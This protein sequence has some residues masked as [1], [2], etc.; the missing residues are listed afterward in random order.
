MA[1][2]TDKMMVMFRYRVVVKSPIPKFVSGQPA[3]FGQY[4]QVAI[5]ISQAGPGRFQTQAIVNLKGGGMASVLGHYLPDALPLGA[6]PPA[7]KL[8]SNHNY[9]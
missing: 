2:L 4:P 1:V 6:L 8:F 7:E 9:Y 3:L 5:N